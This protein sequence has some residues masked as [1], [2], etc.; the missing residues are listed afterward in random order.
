MSWRSQVSN[1]VTLELRGSSQTYVV[2]GLSDVAERRRGEPGDNLLDF[3]VFSHDGR[4][5]G[6]REVEMWMG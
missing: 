2:G 4:C 6:V 3:D 5:L 1:R